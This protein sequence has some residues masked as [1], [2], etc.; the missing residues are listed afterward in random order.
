VPGIKIEY[1]GQAEMLP[2]DKRFMLLLPILLVIAILIAFGE[3]SVGQEIAAMIV[4]P[5]QTVI[6]VNR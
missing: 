4:P 5:D 3:T 6:A 1:E 2:D